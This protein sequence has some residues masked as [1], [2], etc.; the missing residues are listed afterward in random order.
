[1]GRETYSIP[2]GPTDR[3]NFQGNAIDYAIANA[4]D[5][6]VPQ[7]LITTLIAFRSTYEQRYSVANNKN[8]QSKVAI[9]DRDESWGDIAVP[10]VELYDQYLMNNDAISAADKIALNINT[11]DGRG[12]TVTQAAITTPVVVL[13]AS[14]SSIL[15]VVFTDSASVS[16]SHAK[17]DGVAFCEIWAKIDGAAPVSPAECVEHYNIARNNQAVVFDSTQRTKT[18][19]GFARW[20]NRNGKVG[21]WS[22]T[23]S[24]II[25]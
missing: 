1:M 22:N 23:F 19:Y 5:W 4:A 8:T 10:L 24:A 21:I 3:H 17:P 6:G 14:D 16:G 7:D 2:K 9:A 15:R 11:Y 25:P 12:V 13:V 18:V 20:V